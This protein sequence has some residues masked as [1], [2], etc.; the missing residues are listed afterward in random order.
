MATAQM[1]WF[2]WLPEHALQD[3]SAYDQ[4]EC[5]DPDPTCDSEK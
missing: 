1:L 3:D 5:K 2:E 4:T